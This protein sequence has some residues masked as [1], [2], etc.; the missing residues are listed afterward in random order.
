[1][2]RN[3]PFDEHV[4]RG[5]LK[6]IGQ[7]GQ[8]LDQARGAPEQSRSSSPAP[9]GPAQ[10]SPP[11]PQGLAQSS[12]PVPQ[13]AQQGDLAAR[14]LLALMEQANQGEAGEAPPVEPPQPVELPP[15]I[16]PPSMEPPSSVESSRPA[17]PPPV[18]ARFGGARQTP[19]GVPEPNPLCLAV[20]DCDEASRR[21]A[22]QRGEE[23]AQW[24]EGQLASA[25][26]TKS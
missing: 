16:E 4:A 1:M 25:G 5:L 14:R 6:V 8:L 2:S 19:A 20:A 23:L 13:G 22:P 17:K 9:Q 24:L 10:S 3:A 26:P 15:S 7:A 18:L 21:P 12:C 11:A